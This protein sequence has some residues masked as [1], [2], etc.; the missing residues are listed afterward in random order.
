MKKL[1]LCLILGML[2]LMSFGQ[3]NTGSMSVS[4]P[5]GVAITSDVQNGNSSDIHQFTKNAVVQAKVD[6]NGNI[7]SLVGNVQTTSSTVAAA[8]HNVTGASNDMLDL[9]K[10]STTVAKFDNGGNL[11]S[12]GN[13]QTTSS[14]VAAAVHNVTGAS[15]DM[16]DF[17]KNGTTIAKFDNSGNLVSSA[18][19]IITTSST[20]SPGVSVTSSSGSTPAVYAAS[21][22][23]VPAISRIT[24]S[25]TS[26]IHEFQNASAVAVAKV[27]ANGNV[28]TVGYVA[29]KVGSAVT[30]AATISPTGKIFHIV[31][32]PINITTINLPANFNST[33]GGEITIVPDYAAS[34]Y[35]GGNIGRTIVAT[36]NVPITFVYDGTYWW[37]K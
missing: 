27:D 18:Q 31:Y 1:F 34:F 37:P 11:I 25:N 30:A 15:N 6:N 12:T 21:S 20:T 3:C 24:G 10:N 26:N 9:Q 36:A 8:V 17:Q 32:A 29:H 4:S 23:N 28:T 14:T 16:T 19:I 35:T 33:T 2:Y 13:V 22:A 5:S 7:I